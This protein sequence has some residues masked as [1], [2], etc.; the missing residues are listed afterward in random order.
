[1]A[2][3]QP[4]TTITA[5]EMVPADAAIRAALASTREADAELVRLCATYQAAVDAYNADS[6]KLEAVDDPLWHRVQELEAKIDGIQ[7]AGLAGVM[8]K[9]RIAHVRA[10]AGESEPWATDVLNDMMRLFGPAT[11]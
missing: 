10:K 3:N 5:G 9:A 1:M 8:A 6:G 2:I 4:T 11:A 7:P